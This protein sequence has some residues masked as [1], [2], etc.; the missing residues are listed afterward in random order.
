MYYEINV[1][2]KTSAGYRHFFATA[3][4]SLSS[5]L[6]ALT[7]LQALLTA[8]PEPEYNISLTRWEHKGQGINIKKLIKKI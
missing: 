3:E 1:S 7:V 4:R 5:E 6:Q 8:F 2:K